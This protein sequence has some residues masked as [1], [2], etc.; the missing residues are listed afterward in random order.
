MNMIG[1]GKSRL[2]S[3]SSRVCRPGL[4]HAPRWRL[5]RDTKIDLDTLSFCFLQ[6]CFG[7]LMFRGS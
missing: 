7:M 2:C 6:G 1:F 3:L 5:G 4:A